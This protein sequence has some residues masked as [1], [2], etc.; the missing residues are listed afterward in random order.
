MKFKIIAIAC[1]ALCSASAFAATLN[2]VTQVPDRTFFIGG[3]SAQSAAV[4]AVVPDLFDTT[5][6]AV[7]A[8][9]SPAT[10]QAAKGWYGMSK[11]SVTGG[12]SQRL[13]VVYNNTNGSAAGVSQL[14]STATPPTQPE[15]DI[16][17][18]GNSGCSAVASN[19]S[20]CTNHAPTVID[21]ALS[22]VNISELVPGVVPTGAGYITAGQLTSVKT[23]LQGFGVIVNPALYTALQNQNI[24]EGLLGSACAGSAT[25][26]CQPSIRRADYASL[27]NLEGTIKDAGGLL[28]NPSDTTDVNLFRRDDASGTQ[29]SSNIFFGNNVCGT[30]G[31]LGAL[32]PAGQFDSNPGVLDITMQTGTGGVT[33]GV[34]ASGGY[35]IGVVGLGT[36]QGANT[37]KYVKLDGVSPNFNPDGSVDTTQRNAFASGRYPFAFEMYAMYRNSATTVTKSLATTFIA[38]LKDSTKHN[39]N[40]IAYLDGLAYVAGGKQSYVNRGGNNC[41][42]L[43]N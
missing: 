36:L 11:A 42:P 6:Y 30:L 35:A 9:T 28:R 2:P 13:F 31:Y 25:A 37:W 23:A 8:I 12:T 15:A 40:G 7:L 22:D 14:V 27:V 21:M 33:G 20:V 26:A 18:I 39:L 3:S 43:I 19:A 5:T 10:A 32:S 4:A 34:A 29:A 41:Q 1:A 16:V 24:T 17:T 38:G